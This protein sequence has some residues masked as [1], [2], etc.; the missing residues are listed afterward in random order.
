MRPKSLILLAMA[1][2]CGLV[3]A[4][5]INQIL[6]RPA[7]EV[8]TVG[9]VV[10][11]REIKKGD[12][13][14]PD[15]IRLQEWHIDSLP[16]GSIQKIDELAERR[17]KSNIV[18]GEAILKTKL[19]GSGGR[20]DV[21]PI[22]EGM[23]GV[24]IRV[25]NVSGGAGLI[26][27]GDNVDVLLH[28]EANPSK[29]IPTTATKTLLRNAKVYACDD[30]TDRIQ[31]NGENSIAAKTIMLLLTP[32]Q[33][34]I[35]THA[36]EIGNI[37][38]V[39]RSIKSGEEDDSLDTTVSTQEVLGGLAAKSTTASA[40]QAPIPGITSPPQ[41]G[42]GKEPKKGMGGLDEFLEVMKQTRD[43]G[44]S[45]AKEQPW[46]MVVIEGTTTKELE[47][48]KEAR[49]GRVTGGTGGEF[50]GLGAGASPLEPELPDLPPVK[51][52]DPEEA[53]ESVK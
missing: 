1:L 25:D 19:I 16:E 37:R 22:P 35:V 32:K 51:L 15:D 4:V 49:F 5:G 2:G 13:I 20:D 24:A 26:L 12:M 30:V 31:E 8:Q 42:E 7:S 3:A 29:N 47:F 17:V 52:P 48:S 40:D 9:I 39:L 44:A 11:K 34:A 43:L 50:G 6:A 28:V 18:P 10:A 45:E 21:D 38:L 36:T 23:K 53:D 14:Q 46:K 41:T 33:A 27:P